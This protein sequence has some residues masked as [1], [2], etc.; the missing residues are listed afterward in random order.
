ML[1]VGIP[2]FYFFCFTRNTRV[3]YYTVEGIIQLWCHRGCWHDGIMKSGRHLFDT[4]CM[5]LKVTLVMLLS[6]CLKALL[7]AGVQPGAAPPWGPCPSTL[8]GTKVCLI[9]GS[10][11]RSANLGSGRSK[12][13]KTINAT[14]I[15]LISKISPTHL[16]KVKYMKH[17]LLV[18]L[19]LNEKTKNKNRKANGI[20]IDAAVAAVSNPSCCFF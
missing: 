13:K 5:N 10:V 8:G 6:G 19:L 1:I 20:S 14:W 18:V 17:L 7:S 4:M 12:D 15:T 9:S 3:C 16:A 11:F 2:H